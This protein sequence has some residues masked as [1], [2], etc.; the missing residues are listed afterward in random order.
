MQSTSKPPRSSEYCFV[1]GENKIPG[2]AGKFE[3]DDDTTQGVIPFAVRETPANP[4]DDQTEPGVHSEVLRY[5]RCEITE[6]EMEL[7]TLLDSL[8]TINFDRNLLVSEIT[9]YENKVE[10]LEEYLKTLVTS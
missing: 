7:G 1:R 5:L 3:W 10:Q 4:W 9:E 6:N 8:E 2:I